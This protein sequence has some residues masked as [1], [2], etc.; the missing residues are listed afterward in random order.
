MDG[1]MDVDHQTIVD[2][3][4]QPGAGGRDGRADDEAARPRHPKASLPQPS[5]SA[6]AAARRCGR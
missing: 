1:G 6:S 5:S 4:T 3:P 2:E